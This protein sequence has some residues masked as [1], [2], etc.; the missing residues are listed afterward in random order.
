MKNKDLSLKRIEQ[1]DIK[2]NRLK[3]ELSRRDINK[4]INILSEIKEI[5]EDLNSIIERD[6]NN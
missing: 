6:N 4:G 3:S 2:L 1:L 5:L